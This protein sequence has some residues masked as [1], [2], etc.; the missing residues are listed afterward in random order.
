VASGQPTRWGYLVMWE[1]VVRAGMEARFEQV[2][3]PSG[4]WA[5]LFQQ[6]ENYLGTELTRGQGPPPRYITLDFWVSEATYERFREKRRKEYEAV[7]R[8]CG[9]LRE[10]ER[11]L[12][13][14][15]RMV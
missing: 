5:R 9:W 7:D 13:T 4:D 11:K 10:S 15:V 2:Y 6:D 8:E 1:F 3:G 12:G 14:F